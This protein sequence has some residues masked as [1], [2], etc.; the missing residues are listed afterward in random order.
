MWFFTEIESMYNYPIVEQMKIC[1]KENFQ[2]KR[3]IG[4]DGKFLGLGVSDIDGEILIKKA[5]C[6][7]REA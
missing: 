6:L 7:K 4:S 3:G 5:T 2:V 1:E